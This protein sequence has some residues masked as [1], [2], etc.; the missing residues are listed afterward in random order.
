M[1]VDETF[2]DRADQLIGVANQQLDDISRGKVSASFMYAQA[3]YAA[4]VSACGFFSAEQ[5]AAARSE[6][7]DYFVK[8]FQFM[9]EENLNDYIQNFPV[10]MTPATKSD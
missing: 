2:Y 10:Y 4:W 9:L 8:Q 3:R 1:E 7:V 5:M 6:T